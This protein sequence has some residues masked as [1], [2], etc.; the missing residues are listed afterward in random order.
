V[1]QAEA[2]YE[3]RKADV[4]EEAAGKPPWTGPPMMSKSWHTAVMQQCRDVAEV[5]DKVAF[6]WIADWLTALEQ[7]DEQAM[8]MVA[9]NLVCDIPTHKHIVWDCTAG[10]VCTPSSRLPSRAARS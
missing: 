1:Q 4:D 8:V 5:S 6:E 9:H 2:A 7:D 3:K 10:L